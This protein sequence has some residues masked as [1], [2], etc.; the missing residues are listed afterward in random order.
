MNSAKAVSFP[1]AQRPFEAA[2]R[3]RA[4]LSQHVQEPL[5]C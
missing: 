3:I 5:G 1:D 2:R 4:A